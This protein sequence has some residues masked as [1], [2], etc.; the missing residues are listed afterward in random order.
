M[1]TEAILRFDGKNWFGRETI[2]LTTKAMEAG[3]MGCVSCR[4]GESPSIPAV[5]AAGSLSRRYNR[6]EI[7]LQKGFG[8]C[9]RTQRKLGD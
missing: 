7:R 2:V 3:G 1:R 6:W 8:L 9:Q 5:Y 4:G